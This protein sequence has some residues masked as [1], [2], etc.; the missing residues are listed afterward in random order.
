MSS[1]LE[2]MKDAMAQDLF[3]MTKG[4]AHQRGVCIQCG[5][6]PAFYPPDN[7]DPRDVREYEISGLC[8]ACFDRICT[9]PVDAD[10]AMEALYEFDDSDLWDDARSD[11]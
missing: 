4:M 8:P 2:R 11:E 1:P 3:G 7:P 6:P 9:P 5:Q 10:E